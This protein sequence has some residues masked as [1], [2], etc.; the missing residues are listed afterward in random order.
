MPEFL[1]IISP[2]KTVSWNT[3]PCYL[4]EIIRRFRWIILP[5]PFKTYVSVTE[6]FPIASP[7]KVSVLWNM[8][9]ETLYKFADVSV[10]SPAS[11]FTQRGPPKR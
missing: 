3:T 6:F 8:A 9:S 5:P 7:L 1:P 2:L 10:G 4:V 11:S